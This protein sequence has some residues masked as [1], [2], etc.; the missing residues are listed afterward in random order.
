MQDTYGLFI[1]E[2]QTDALLTLLSAAETAFR[3]EDTFWR[4][5][6]KTEDHRRPDWLNQ[7]DLALLQIETHFPTVKLDSKSGV[8][9][10]ADI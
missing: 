2:T 10:K 1:T 5:Q 6:K 7:L 8:W 9:S 4:E 3:E